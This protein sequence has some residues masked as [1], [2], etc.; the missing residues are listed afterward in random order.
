MSTAERVCAA[1]ALPLPPSLSP[2][3]FVACNLRALVTQYR[4]R[5]SEALRATG[6]RTNVKSPYHHERGMRV[7]TTVFIVMK[8]SVSESDPRLLTLANRPQRREP[9]RH[10]RQTARRS[11]GPAALFSLLA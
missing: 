8:G 10:G 5:D 11:H 1:A 9:L 7:E 6:T 3:S 2:L 4:G